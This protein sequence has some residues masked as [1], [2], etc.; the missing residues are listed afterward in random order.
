MGIS[1]LRSWA[2]QSSAGLDRLR[3]QLLLSSYRPKDEAEL[4]TS[5]ADN[6]FTEDYAYFWEDYTGHQPALW[7]LCA[8]S[9]GEPPHWSRTALMSWA[10]SSTCAVISTAKS[11]TKFSNFE[12]SVRADSCLYPNWALDSAVSLRKQRETNRH[13]NFFPPKT[14]KKWRRYQTRIRQTTQNTPTVATFSSPLIHSSGLFCGFF[15]F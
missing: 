15:F 12:Y 3:M 14:E 1:R 6:V 9:H 8:A 10:Y 7:T 5:S 2:L 4:P 11:W 13:E